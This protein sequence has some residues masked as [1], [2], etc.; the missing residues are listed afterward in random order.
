[1]SVEH[2]TD[3]FLHFYL[4]GLLTQCLTCMK[5]LIKEKW[6][7]QSSSFK[8]PP[9]DFD[10][11][12]IGSILELQK[13]SP[14]HVNLSLLSIKPYIHLFNK[15]NLEAD[16]INMES[17]HWHYK[18]VILPRKSLWSFIKL[19]GGKFFK[20]YLNV[21]KNILHFLKLIFKRSKANFYLVLSSLIASETLEWRNKFCLFT[22]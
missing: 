6:L 17:S 4:T 5:W 8:T 22:L 18:L 7:N 3:Y 19:A 15:T 11:Y 14:K 9:V 16:L 13:S 20:G 12:N 21:F 1:M 10:F 2:V